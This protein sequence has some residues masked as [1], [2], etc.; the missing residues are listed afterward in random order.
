MGGFFILSSDYLSRDLSELM[1]RYCLTIICFVQLSLYAQISEP[2]Q[3]QLDSLVTNLPRDI[4]RDLD[5]AHYYLHNA[6]EN[7]EERVFLYYGFIGIHFKYDYNR[8]GEGKKVKEYTTY[9]T[10][11]KRS[12]V[13]RDFAALF[14]ELCNRSGMPCVVATGRTKSSYRRFFR[15]MVQ[16]KFRA[17]NHAWNIVKFNGTWHLMDPTWTWVDKTDKYYTYDENGR[18]KYKT[19]AK[20]PARDY[21]DTKPED[22]YKKRSAVHPAYYTMTTVPTFNTSRRSMR[23][24]TTYQTNYDY[25]SVLDSIDAKPFYKFSKSYFMEQRAYCPNYGAAGYDWHYISSYLDLKRT[26][27]DALTVE[28]CQEYI[29]YLGDLKSFFE[30]E[31]LS[32]MATDV[33]WTTNEIRTHIEKLERRAARLANRR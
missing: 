24:K 23:N 12:G 10:C 20:R 29:A 33:Q 1:I 4:V 6:G 19:K 17:P 30:S 9:Y 5:S 31:D 3:K 21:Y 14:K 27:K 13:C 22:F 16:F 2:R 15:E 32:G 25:S 18:K 28:R 8:L 7:N 11:K 26:K